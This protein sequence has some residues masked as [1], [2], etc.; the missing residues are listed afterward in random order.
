MVGENT[1]TTELK[2][3]KVICPTY[4]GEDTITSLINVG[5]KKIKNDWAFLLF[6]GSRI[7][8]YLEHKI[9]TLVKKEQDVLF[10]VVAR[11][12]DFISGSFNGV[13]MNRKFFY[14]VGEFEVI[15]MKKPDLNDFELAKLFWAVDAMD[16][17]VCFKAVVGM[18][19]I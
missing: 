16:K 18:K 11:K 17:G 5:M 2:E 8:T 19:V 1:T 15:K 12:S 9:A 10:P 3:F 4:K 14:E 6:A 7:P 13:L